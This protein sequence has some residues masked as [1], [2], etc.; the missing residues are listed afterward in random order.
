VC[1]LR[2][3]GRSQSGAFVNLEN[4][5]ARLPTFAPSR[6]LHLQPGQTTLSFAKAGTW[7]QVHRGVLVVQAAPQWLGE[8]IVAPVQRVPAGAGHGVAASGWLR[9]SAEAGPVEL[10]CRV[11]PPLVVGWFAQVLVRAWAGRPLALRWRHPE[12]AR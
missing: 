6:V 12:R 10:H 3:G 2:C 9:L 7:L 8:R 1:L 5:M 11:P 4:E